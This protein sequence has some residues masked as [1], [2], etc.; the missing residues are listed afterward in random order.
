MALSRN[1]RIMISSRGISDR[2]PPGDKR[3]ST[4]ETIRKKLKNDIQAQDLF[5]S[6]AFEVWINEDAP[7]EA[8]TL[9]SWEICLNAVR[10]SDI[11][12]VLYNGNA[13]W[14]KEEG[15]I[16]ICHA[17]LA[18]AYDTAPGKIRLINLGV[19]PTDNSDS[20]KRN[21]RFQNYVATQSPF[22]GGQVKTVEH[23]EQRVGEALRD[24]VVRLTQSGVLEASRG[25]SYTGQSLDWNR[26]NF[27][28]RRH[29]IISVLRDAVAQRTN[30]TEDK[31]NLLV[32]LDKQEVLFVTDAVPAAMSVSAAREIV[33]Q[34]FLKDHTRND[35]LT[36]KRGGPVHLI[37]CHKN[38]TEAQAMK[39]LG[40]SDA[41]VI[42]TPFGVYVADNVQKIQL[43]LIANCRDDANT[44]HGVQRFFEWLQQT[45]EGEL[46]VQRAAA[47]ARI[48]KSIAQE[49]IAK[50]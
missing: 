9:D 38:I 21:K 12:L 50:V 45:G 6:K 25:S 35:I 16:G 2:F 47:R 39:L 28:E 49:L 13:G 33:G 7:P 41:T 30:A 48:V 29:A 4:L 46:L 22:R 19:I 43:V 18:T 40:F 5:G 10:E 23:L 20:G 27:A 34:P 44:R 11:L 31:G 14:A 1:I 17:E 32:R 8:G 36:G 15:E 37:G 42:S 3:S 26:M 24:A